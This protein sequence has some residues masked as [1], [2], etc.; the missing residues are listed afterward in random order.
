MACMEN[1]S[2]PDASSDPPRLLVIMPAHNEAESIVKT[3][4]QL[5][6]ELPQADVVVVNDGSTDATP[7]L[8]RQSGAAVLDLACNLGVGGAMQAGYLYAV[9]NGYDLAVQFDAD[10]QHRANQVP[11]LLEPILAGQADLV[12][13]SRILGGIKYRFSF[14]RFLGSRLLSRLVSLL[15]RRKLT[16]PT[17]G[18]RA[19]GRRAILFF[20]RHYPQAWLGDTVEALVEL[21]RHGMSIAEVPVKMRVR[22]GGRSAAGRITGFVHTLRIILAVLID[23]ME[24]RFDDVEDA[25]ATTEAEGSR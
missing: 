8:A 1:A 2:K 21:S 22:T 14:E 25:P 18:F 12:V 16:D 9:Q 23:V 11:Q 6:R 20:S 5:S 19:A 10:G 17:S 3:L 15:T 7:R 4:G 24:S 13:G